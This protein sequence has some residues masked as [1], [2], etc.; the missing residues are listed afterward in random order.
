MQMSK[1]EVLNTL[2]SENNGYIRTSDVIA[3]G[4]SKTYFAEFIRSNELKRA[5]HGLYMSQDAWDD[6]LFV[7]QT[8]YPNAIFSHETALY[9]LGLG[10]REPSP[11]SLTLMTRSSSATLSKEGVK[12]YKI[13]NTLFDLGLDSAK[14]PAGHTVRIY[15]RERTVCDMVRSR[16]GLEIHDVQSA[17]KAYLHAKDKNIP[18]LMRYAKELSVEKIIRQYT[19]VLL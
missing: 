1:K 6:G 15:N 3:A 8:R 9:M 12:V 18:Q 7:L 13:K 17:I 11:Y 2:L 10:E 4:V 19:E 5:A 14:T 16:N